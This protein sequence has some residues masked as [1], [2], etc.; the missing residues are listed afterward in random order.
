[1]KLQRTCA[2]GTLHHNQHFVDRSRARHLPLDNK[3]STKLFHQITFTQFNSA[4]ISSTPS[5]HQPLHSAH[6]HDMDCLSLPDDGQ[7]NCTNLWG[8]NC[9]N[10]MGFEFVSM[11]EITKRIQRYCPTHPQLFLKDNIA[12][13]PE[14][15]ALTGAT[16]KVI[17]GSTWQYYPAAAIWVRLA[18]WKFPL[19]Q[20]VASSPRPSLSLAV[21]RFVILH[22]LGDPI[23]TCKDLLRVISSCQ[24]RA[25]SWRTYLSPPQPG[26]PRLDPIRADR[27]WKAFSIITISYDEWGEGDDANYILEASL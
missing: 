22:L 7:Y 17:A 16:C 21:E 15:A 20:L 10:K 26:R 23:G 12:A 2:S 25:E 24:R 18:T 3:L 14:N 27:A 13:T 11:W 8:I 6:Y 1:M 19:L 9:I 5:R 4:I